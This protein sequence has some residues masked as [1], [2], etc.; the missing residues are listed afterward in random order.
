MAGLQLSSARCPESL[1]WVG[2]IPDV[3]VADLGALGCGEA[4]DA[5]GGDFPGFG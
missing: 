3:E 2:Q 4:D 1:A 5:A